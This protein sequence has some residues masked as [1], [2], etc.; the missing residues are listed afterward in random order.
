LPKI[1]STVLCG[2][3]NLDRWYGPPRTIV[4]VVVVFNPSVCH[5]CHEISQDKNENIAIIYSAAEGGHKCEMGYQGRRRQCD[6]F[7][8]DVESCDDESFGTNGV[9]GAEIRNPVHCECFACLEDNI[10][11]QCSVN[12]PAV[13][14]MSATTSVLFYQPLAYLVQSPTPTRSASIR[15]VLPLN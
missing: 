7:K 6:G 9:R 3:G 13:K 1:R 8:E 12:R 11:L 10:M 14:A 15:L 4:D 2:C 5:G